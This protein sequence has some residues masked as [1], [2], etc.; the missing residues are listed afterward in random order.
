LFQLAQQTAQ[1]TAEFCAREGEA[2]AALYKNFLANYKGRKEGER[3]V[4]EGERQV[5]GLRTCDSLQAKLN[6][7][8]AA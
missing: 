2:R 3:Q 8:T 5:P 6:A 7:K 1:Q 4:P